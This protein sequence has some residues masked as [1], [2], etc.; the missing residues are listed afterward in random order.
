MHPATPSI[1][2]PHAS[3]RRWL[4]G[5]NFFLADVRDGLGPFLGV[6][7]A[8][9]G[10]RADDIGYVMAAGGIAGMLATTPMGAWIDASRHKRLLLA[11]GTLALI[12]ATAALWTAPI[13]RRR[14]RLPGCD[15][16]CGRI[17]GRRHHGHHLGHR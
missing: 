5:L 15:G 3:S 4:S 7:L 9:Q 8:S 17:D 12:L 2:P 14:R 11:S 6:F 10:W 1:P 16:C 13:V